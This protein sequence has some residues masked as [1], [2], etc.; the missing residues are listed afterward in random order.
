M[1]T[2]P[3]NI[4]KSIVNAF[5]KLPQRVLLKYEGEIKN[6]PENIMTV[7]WFPQRDVLSEFYMI[8]IIYLR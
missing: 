7:E 3:E 4:Q 2:I 5:A 1:S 6:K 8:I